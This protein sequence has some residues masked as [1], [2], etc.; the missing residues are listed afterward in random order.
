MAAAA[1]EAAAAAKKGPSFVV[2][3]AV[4]LV[5]TL[6]A[7]GAG[8]FAG[9]F[10]HG[11]QAPEAQA[12]APAESAK[13]KKGEGEKPVQD[14]HLFPLETITTNLADPT[15]VWVR[16]ELTLVFQ[17]QPDAEIAAMVHQD[18]LAYLRTVKARQVAGASGFQHLKSDLDERAQ[19][20]SGGKV[21]RVLV[22][23]LLFE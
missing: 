8:W 16:L 1:A 6:A 2:Q 11:E 17:D 21:S 7:V 23:T 22:K 19:I 13:G 10:L 18:F 14:P 4:L 20:R 9:R 15:D 5:L 12:A 3:I